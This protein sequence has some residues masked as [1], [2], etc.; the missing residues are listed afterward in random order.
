MSHSQTVAVEIIVYSQHN[1]SYGDVLLR[2][3][4]Q[5]WR[6]NVPVNIPR[7]MMI[8]NV[9]Y[10]PSWNEFQIK[11]A[12]IDAF[13]NIKEISVIRIEN[14]I[15]TIEQESDIVFSNLNFKKFDHRDFILYTRG[16]WRYK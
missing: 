4:L 2:P 14:G 8:D 15:E 3:D 6:I 1:N 12:I 13:D 11:I 7:S 9:I 16:E 10:D 5:G